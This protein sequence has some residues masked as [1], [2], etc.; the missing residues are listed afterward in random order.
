VFLVRACNSGAFTWSCVFHVAVLLGIAAVAMS[1]AFR[2][3]G[4]LLLS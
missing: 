1:I 3:L 4:T 2:R